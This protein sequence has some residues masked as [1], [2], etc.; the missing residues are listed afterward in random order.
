MKR[1]ILHT[2]LISF[3]LG[4]LSCGESP[5][6]TV[7]PK[8]TNVETSKPID[9]TDDYYGI[10]LNSSK[11]DFIDY[12]I[13]TGDNLVSIF[14]R[15]K[16]GYDDINRMLT[17]GSKVFETDKISNRSS[18]TLL[19]SKG[20][21]N[22]SPRCVIL[23]LSLIDHVVFD[24]RGQVRVSLYKEPVNVVE[25]NSKATIKRSL[26]ET[27]KEK[28]LSDDLPSKI[29][30]IFAWTVDFFKL[31]RGDNFKVI[32]TE[33][34]IKDSISVG[35]DRV[36]AVVF[37]HSGKKYY[38]FNSYYITTD[39]Y[40]G[41]FDQHGRSLRKTFL[42]SPLKFGRLSSRYTR[43]RYHPVLKVW[44]AHKGT[45]YAAARG[46]PILSTAAGTIETYGYSSG[47]GR[48]VKV[49]H[50]SLYA[51]QYLHMSRFARIY[52]GKKVK[53]GDIIG[54][55]GSS[56]LATGPHVCYRFWYRGRQRDPLRVKLP[57]AR[58]V[59]KDYRDRFQ[60]WISPY[61]ERLDR[62]P[63]R[64]LAQT[65]RKMKKYWVLADEMTL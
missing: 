26:F 2:V 52:K 22:T 28:H 16:F 36:K 19:F 25:K 27:I 62:Y 56:G 64:S 38:A 14:H 37:T 21:R 6:V 48:Y 44:K 8:I 4:L 5:T 58:S 53:Q 3:A 1:F 54:Y 60:E 45:D 41:F 10:K 61:R 18:Y 12:K 17:A 33:K 63:Y 57:L 13:K 35:I 51:T 43:R 7:S 59:K 23:H 46:T 39:H 11:Y 42:K 49:K 34:F 15:N 29:S 40:T 50:N 31:Q 9:S 20:Q 32:Y 65:H 30:S 55:V 47:N 24:C